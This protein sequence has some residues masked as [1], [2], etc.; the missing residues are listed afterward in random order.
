MMSTERERRNRARARF[1]ARGAAVV[2]SKKVIRV[3][4][5]E[6]IT[7]PLITDYVRCSTQDLSST[8][9]SPSTRTMGMHA[10]DPNIVLCGSLAAGVTGVKDAVR[11]D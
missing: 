11:F 1:A 6:L 8:R 5:F 2:I 9:T 3:G 4:L 7:D 10:L